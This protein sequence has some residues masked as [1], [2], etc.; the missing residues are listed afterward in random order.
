MITM[1]IEVPQKAVRSWLTFLM[2][3]D[4][5]VMATPNSKTGAERLEVFCETPREMLRLVEACFAA[6]VAGVSGVMEREGLMP[7][8]PTPVMGLSVAPAGVLAT[9]A[10]CGR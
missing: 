9:C 6:G 2:Q 3:H 10:S 8:P 7:A 1:T 4:Y 5:C